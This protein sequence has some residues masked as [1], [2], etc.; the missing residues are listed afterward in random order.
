[1]LHQDEGCIPCR[2]QKINAWLMQTFSS[3]AINLHFLCRAKGLRLET[4]KVC[5]TCSSETL[6]FK[7][8]GTCMNIHTQY[9]PPPLS[10]VSHT[11]C[12]ARLRLWPLSYMCVKI[13]AK[14]DPALAAQSVCL[15]K[16]DHLCVFSVFSLQGVVKDLEG[17]MLCSEK[18]V[19]TRLS[20]DKGLFSVLDSTP[21]VFKVSANKLNSTL[22]KLTLVP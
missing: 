17:W 15:S 1:M 7:S 4:W 19:I 3:A 2:S 8:A 10:L 18:T 14:A 20:Q 21:L 22:S 13:S 5:S 9:T 11:V 6:S 12:W 16:T